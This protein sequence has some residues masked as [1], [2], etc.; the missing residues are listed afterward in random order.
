VSINP[1]TYKIAFVG[2]PNVGKSSLFNTL[3]GLKQKVGN[4]PGVTVERK[5]GFCKLD[6]QKKV[7]IVDL[8]GIYSLFVKTPD[9][10]VVL[11]ALLDKE[12]IHYPDLIVFFIDALNLERSLVLF[13]QIKDLG[14]PLLPVITMFDL[15]SNKGIEI[16]IKKLEENLQTEVIAINARKGVGVAELKKSLSAYQVSKQTDAVLSEFEEKL[17][18]QEG[19]MLPFL[20]KDA[21]QKYREKFLSSSKDIIDLQ[22]ED[23]IDRMNKVHVL[24]NDVISYPSK[25]RKTL[26]EKID[27]IVTHP[28]LGYLVYFGVLMLMFQF[29]FSLAEYPMSLIENAFSSING[30]L[31]NNLSPGLLTDL[32]TE[33]IITGISGVVIFIPQIALLFAFISVLEES[34]YMSRVVYLM[35]KPMRV[36]GLSGKSV[37]PLISGAACAVPAIMSARGIENW[38]ER[39][40]TIFVTPFISCS[41]RLPVYI[42]IIALIIPD[43]Y[44]WGFSAK[45][46]TL[47]FLYLLGILIALLTSVVFSIYLKS[48]S[49][50]LFVIDIPSY[51][52]PR[53]KNVFNTIF[54]KTKTFVLEAGKIILTISVLLWALAS[55]GPGSS[56]EKAEKN[57]AEIV[58]TAPELNYEEV[59]A[60]QKLE[61]SYIGQFGHFIEPVIR[62]L[63]YDWKIGIALITSFAAREVFVGTLGT[64]YSVGEENFDEKL[65]DKMR[66]EKFAGT[67]RPVY[68]FATGFSLLIFY[69]F[70]LQCLST[71]AVVY[72]ETNS[73]KWTLSQFVYMTALAYILS[74]LTYNILS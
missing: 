18:I 30:L 52:T 72:R 7:E 9:E 59:L 57:A 56:M 5:I 38:K 73:W 21:Q 27:S 53:W 49:K 43:V 8:P 31:K 13:S 68:T 70:A 54:Q 42:I 61:A 2:N 36:F 45:G 25:T 64:I 16:N 51:K 15:A 29:I 55:Y 32:L 3:T 24:L 10:K 60:A 65:V 20:N 50:N 4:F 39:M 33:G 12:N 6:E 26:T 71:I 28:V 40:L 35:D 23:T 14:F 17:S 22:L 47:L 48:S 34:G 44:F 62:P 11:E 58:K 19:L 41:A 1:L 37:V 63:G 69:V 74:L 67:D 66:K 46:L